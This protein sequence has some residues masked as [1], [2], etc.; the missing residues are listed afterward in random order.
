MKLFFKISLSILV[1]LLLFL[2]L[3]PYFE[4]RGINNWIQQKIIKTIEK[5]S[6]NTYKL[7]VEKTQLNIL[8]GRII[9]KDVALKTDTSLSLPSPNPVIFAKTKKILLQGNLWDY[10]LH[11]KIDIETILIENPEIHFFR[12]AKSIKTKK[13]FGKQQLNIDKSLKIHIHKFIAS[14]G[15][16]Y[17]YDSLPAKQEKISMKETRIVLNNISIDSS[18]K[19]IADIKPETFYVMLKDLEY[20]DPSRFY[21][22]NFKKI[23]ITSNAG[24]LFIDSFELVPLYPKYKFSRIAGYQVDRAKCKINNI[25]F[26]AL[27][28]N[29]FVKNGNFTARKIE[30]DDSRLEM[31]RDKRLKRKDRIKKMPQEILRNL[32]F[33]VSIDTVYVKRFDVIYMEFAKNGK[34]PGWMSIE[35]IT[36]S[37]AGLKNDSFADATIKVDAQAYLMGRGYLKAHFNIPIWDPYNSFTCT[38][39]LGRMNMIHFNPILEKIKF[40]SIKTGKINRI[41]LN[42]RGNEDYAEGPVKMYYRNLKVQLLDEDERHKF[43]KKFSFHCRQQFC[44]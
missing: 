5:K 38:A 8:S 21:H 27:D 19:V 31:F 20:K 14:S 10:L 4:N 33:K 43:G 39:Y 28:F 9:F 6:S 2:I 37:I 11:K 13:W 29:D 36:G 23:A 35:N 17:F 25:R 16:F 1:F 3:L 15:S 42:F 7:D 41:N 18:L 40:V 30:L 12:T 32:P 24:G 44:N 22:I 26:T 34:A